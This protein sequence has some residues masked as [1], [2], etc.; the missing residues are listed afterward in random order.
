MLNV[1]W[2]AYFFP[3]TCV[4][5][6][7]WLLD[8]RN[9]F[10]HRNK[11]KTV[12]LLILSKRSTSE[13]LVHSWWGRIETLSDTVL[14][15]YTDC[16]F[17]WQCLFIVFVVGSSLQRQRSDYLLLASNN[18][19]YWSFHSLFPICID[20]MARLFCIL[21]VD[22]CVNRTSLVLRRSS[23]LTR[24][25]EKTLILCPSS[26]KVH[27]F[28]IYWE[29]ELYS[30]RMW[31]IALVLSKAGE[32][33]D[34]KI[35]NTMRITYASMTEC[36]PR[37][38]V[39]TIRRESSHSSHWPWWPSIFFKRKKW[40]VM[41]TSITTAPFLTRATPTRLSRCYWQMMVVFT[42]I[43]SR[44]KWLEWRKECNN[45]ENETSERTE[46]RQ[47]CVCIQRRNER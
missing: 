45:D 23:Q 3:R 7:W 40:S 34:R 2:G 9:S 44:S 18:K 21:S 8:G 22:F 30:H 28:K 31:N 36:F 17:E 14:L 19:R 4:H 5:E 46:R 1:D 42:K 15:A 11:E 35:D 25:E 43:A 29:S 10:S 26:S 32:E 33:F 16:I 41:V 13:Y 39:K 47:E 6:P 20:R 27:D 38:L 24:P 37:T 12:S